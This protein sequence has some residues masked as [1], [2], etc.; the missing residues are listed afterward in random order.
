MKYGL[1]S[2]QRVHA[3]HK[4]IVPNSMHCYHWL[5]LMALPIQG[6]H[7]IEGFNNIEQ[8]PNQSI[9]VHNNKPS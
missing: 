8:R 4:V 3:S 2:K 6:C 9:L 5:N 7:N 1:A